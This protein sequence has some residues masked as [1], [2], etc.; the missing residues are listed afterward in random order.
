MKTKLE[1]E[2]IELHKALLYLF[3]YARYVSII[4]LFVKKEGPIGK[5]K[6]GKFKDDL[7][8]PDGCRIAEVRYH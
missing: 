7:R 4:F 2:D 1:C 3:I 5:M 6:V 8:R